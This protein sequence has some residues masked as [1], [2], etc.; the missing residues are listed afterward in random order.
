MDNLTV[1]VSY[2][3][4]GDRLCKTTFQ[5][6]R[7]DHKTRFLR[8]ISEFGFWKKALAGRLLMIPTH[9]VTQVAILDDLGN[10]YSQDFSRFEVHE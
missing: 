7:Q 6:E 4:V 8:G 10:T 5:F 1:I 3:D 2:R 9:C